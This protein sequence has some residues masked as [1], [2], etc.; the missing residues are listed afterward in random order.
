MTGF[1]IIKIE[2]QAIVPVDYG[3]IR[4]PARMNLS[5]R[6][7]IIYEGIK[8]LLH[9]YLPLEMAIETPFV[10]KNPQGALKLGIT[11]GMALIAAKECKMAV[12]GYSPREVKC[13]VTGTGKA[14]KDQVK[15]TVTQALRLK[16][17]PRPQ[18]AADALA[19]AL[20][21]AHAHSVFKSKKEL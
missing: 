7:A 12:F 17:A 3:C 5:D 2:S 13:A 16:T 21:H 11:L 14:S 18:D 8:T 20:C 9:K 19:I 15:S 6:Y 4:P 10:Y 1:G